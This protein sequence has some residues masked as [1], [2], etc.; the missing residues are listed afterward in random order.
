MTVSRDNSAGDKG[1][2]TA[3]SISGTDITWGTPAVLRGLA[4]LNHDV[5]KLTATTAIVM[6]DEAVTNAL[7][8][9][10]ITCSGTGG[11]TISL[12]DH[13]AFDGDCEFLS[14]APLSETK[15][16]ACYMDGGNSAYGTV[17]V[18]D[19]DGTT[20]SAGTPTVFNS[21]QTTYIHC[22]ELNESNLIALF[23]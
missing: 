9:R 2:A 3:G 19:I 4:S 5:I 15:V 21:S 12:G 20:I 11:R 6:F 7:T 8:A 16:V 23:R 1:K 10:V 22:S 13:V 17:C 18:L 14:F